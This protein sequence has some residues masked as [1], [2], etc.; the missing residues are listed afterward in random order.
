MALPPTIPSSFVPHPG[1]TSSRL[2]VEPTALLN[3]LAYVL[4][5]VMCVLALGVFAYGQLLSSARATKEAELVAAQKAIDPATIENFVRLHN[6]LQ[7]SKTLLSAHPAFSKIFSS[8]EKI[9][10]MKTRF[11]SLHFAIQ[12]DGSARVDGTGIAQ[13][14]NVLAATSQTVASDT[15]IK[16]VVFSNIRVNRGD[17]SVAF[18][19]SAKVEQK[20]LVFDGAYLPTMPEVTTP[21]P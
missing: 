8:F 11:T 10:P 4:L 1:T 21:L 13:S 2:H 6:R 19:L 15:R 18:S 9:L 16:N 20:D 5:G 17:G 7:S 12:E 14:F 3:V